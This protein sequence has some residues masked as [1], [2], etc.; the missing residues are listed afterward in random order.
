MHVRPE[1]GMATNADVKHTVKAADGTTIVWTASHGMLTWAG[2][3]SEDR[4]SHTLQIQ[5]AA[6][7]M[8]AKV[9]IELSDQPGHQIFAERRVDLR[10]MRTWT[11]IGTDD[12]GGVTI[13]ADFSRSL[14]SG[15]VPV[16][17]QGKID[18]APINDAEH[19]SLTPGTLY[20]ADFSPPTASKFFPSH[21]DQFSYFQPVFN[22]FSPPPLHVN[23]FI[24]K[25]I[26]AGAGNP[27]VT[28][29]P[30]PIVHAGR[31]PM[32]V[33][34]TVGD[35][36]NDVDPSTKKLLAK[37]L[38][39]ATCALAVVVMPET[40]PGVVKGL[41][42]AIWAVDGLVWTDNVDNAPDSWW[43]GSEPPVDLDSNLFYD[44]TDLEAGPIDQP[45]VPDY[46]TD[47]GGDGPGGDPS[48][49]LPVDQPGV[50][51]D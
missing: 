1:G 25:A 10:Q 28:S 20:P 32:P 31:P 16:F 29:P 33:P 42:A 39:A 35:W 41:N 17:I 9:T 4:V 47:G 46:G 44:P 14:T 50:P 27:P 22:L 11:S 36:W 18:G 2:G 24:I 40:A 23:P 8:Q 21:A 37:S 7:W 5:P 15:T 19:V 48:P 49:P 30:K 45:D 26:A 13:T 38:I 12:H 51:E 34:M 6:T 3:M 43:N